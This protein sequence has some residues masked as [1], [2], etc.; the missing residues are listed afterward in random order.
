[1]CVEGVEAFVIGKKSTIA[2]VKFCLTIMF[3]FKIGAQIDDYLM[4]SALY[5]KFVNVT[6]SLI[7]GTS[8]SMVILSIDQNASWHYKGYCRFEKKTIVM[9]Q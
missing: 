7:L 1:M 8:T 4:I 9:Q 2:V 6:P 5:H 3:M